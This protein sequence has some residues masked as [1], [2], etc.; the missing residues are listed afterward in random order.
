MTDYRFPDHFEWGT[1]TAAYQIEGAW[2]ADGKGESVWD[3]ISHTKGKIED[4]TNGDVASDFYHHYQ[5]DIPLL[6]K[7]GVRSFRLSISWPRIFPEGTGEINRK[8]VEFYRNVL[9]CLRVNGIKS[10]VTMFHWDLP[11]KLEE[12][13]GWENREIVGWFE[14]YAKTLY[15]EFG[16]LVDRWITL[17]EPLC[18]CMMNFQGDY[19]KAFTVAHNLLMSHGAAVK[20][21]RKAGLKAGLKAEIGIT[22]NL[23]MIY[24]QRP[25]SGEDKAS[26][27]LRML[28]AANLFCDPV[29]KGKY[30]QALFSAL[31]QQR[32][33]PPAVKPEDLEL[34]FQKLDFLG[35]NNY[36]AEYVKADPASPLGGKLEKTGRPKTEMGWE[37]VPEGLYDLIKWVDANYHPPKI[38]ITE[39]GAAC[40]DWVDL[41]G[42]VQDPDRTDYLKRYLMQVH[43][44]IS[45]GIPVAGY[46]V[47]SFLDDFEWQ[48]GLDKR[49]GLVFVDYNSEQKTRIPKESFYWYSDVIKNNGF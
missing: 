1:A 39:N 35:I 36:Y 41:D 8:G 15:A 25:D 42:K 26:A 29:L 3:R 33:V 24:P 2:N 23:N 49:F 48:W 9:K 4:A 37:V 18:V 19:G 5:K 12:R 7:L 14:I 32:I 34:I 22:L 30:P 16:D 21:Y 44:A 27:A 28:F 40:N 38:I 45:E 13:G 10:T 46:Y 11:Q 17:N 47:W 31:E 20:A 6:K 43:R